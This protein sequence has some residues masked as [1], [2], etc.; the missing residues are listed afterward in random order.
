MNSIPRVNIRNIVFDLD[1]TLLHEKTHLVN[2][3]NEYFKSVGI[4][5]S[6]LQIN[7][8]GAWFHKF[9]SEPGIFARDMARSGPDD[10]IGFWFHYLKFYH[11]LLD[12]QSVPLETILP[13]LA[14]KIAYREHNVS[15]MKE[16]E[17]TLSMLRNQGYRLGVLSNRFEP[18]DKVLESYG[19]D[20][21]FE[22]AYTAGEL[23]LAKPD[24]A[25]FNEYVARVGM[26]LEETVYVG[27]N[28]WLDALAS[29]NA[30]MIPILIDVYGWYENPG[31]TSIARISELLLHFPTRVFQ[32]GNRM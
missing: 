19:L 25:I 15:M 28:Y 1:G 21:Y 30:G 10:D 20:K 9:W 23:G 31:V 17:S 14:R 4:E 32:D 3:I 16:T 12:N 18:I 11:E 7:Q 6:R 13:E 2:F 5:L 24:T 27:D 29:R 8:S 26:R 22:Y